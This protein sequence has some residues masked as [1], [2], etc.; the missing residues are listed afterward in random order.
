MSKVN[1]F[2]ESNS[3]KQG[4]LYI[5]DGKETIVICTESSGGEDFKATCL[6]SDN[7]NWKVGEYYE[8]TK[9]ICFVPFYG[10]I[11]LTSI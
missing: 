4:E 8:Q 7:S 10:R 1:K 5:L 9:S 11:E 2:D 3:K 6:V